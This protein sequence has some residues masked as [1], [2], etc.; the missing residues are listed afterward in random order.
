MTKRKGYLSIQRPI[1]R[2]FWGKVIFPVNEA[3]CWE[4]EAPPMKFGYRRVRYKGKA[5]LAHRLAYFLEYGTMPDVVLHRCDNTACVRPSHL[6]AGTQADNIA[7][8]VAKG[9]LVVNHYGRG[10]E[11]K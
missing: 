8:M 10:G 5:W 1:G 4:Y 11:P 7:D 9:R 3:D 6:Q 2:R